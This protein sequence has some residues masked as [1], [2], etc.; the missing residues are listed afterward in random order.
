MHEII[1]DIPHFSQIQDKESKVSEWERKICW[2]TCIKMCMEFFCGDS[3]SL[4]ELLEY[5]DCELIWLS[6]KDWIERKYTYYLPWIGWFHYWLVLI[7][8]LRWLFWRSLIIKKSD[9]ALK[10]QELLDKWYAIIASVSLWFEQ[11][12]NNWWHLV[13]LR[14]IKSWRYII[15]DPM[16][17]NS[18]EL[19]M[20]DFE[21]C[22]SWAII[23]IS[24]EDSEEFSSNKPI[25]IEEQI[26]SSSK[27]AYVHLHGNE[28]IALEGTKEFLKENSWILLS[29]NQNRERFLRYEITCEGNDKI[30]LRIDP[31]RIFDDENLTKTIL[32]R[33]SHLDKSL[34]PIAFEKWLFIRNY[35]LSKLK[36]VNPDN[37]IWVHTNK[38]L[39]INDFIKVTSFTYVNDEMSTNSFIQ[40][41]DKRDFYKLKDLR[42]NCIYFTGLENDWSLSDYCLNEGIRYFTIESWYRDVETFR[43]LLNALQKII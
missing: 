11:K 42:I 22:F 12:E 15:N 21:K 5:K 34:L 32:E 20:G 35:I 7:A 16:N 23:I 25:Y 24:K 14:W 9:T 2:L 41:I 18:I 36:E 6:L 39:N 3:P 19:S 26:N 37:I 8:A 10:F 13:V 28:R 17:R 31:N 27:N 40:A 33:N 30:F 4:E 43:I 38:L 29:I 1:L